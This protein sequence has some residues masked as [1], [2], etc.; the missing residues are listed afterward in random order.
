MP[1]TTEELAA[2]TTDG[3]LAKRGFVPTD[4]IQRATSLIADWYRN[5]MDPTE[6]ISYTQRTFA[7]ELGSHPDLLA[8]FTSSG[9]LD[10]VTSLVGAFAPVTTAQIQIRVPESELPD[11]PYTGRLGGSTITPGT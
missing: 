4:L 2:F 11:A 6:I 10:V 8:L 3:V 1:L 7:P 5:R 9:V